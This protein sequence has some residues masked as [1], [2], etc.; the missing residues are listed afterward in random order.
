MH[1]R[2]LGC[3]IAV[4]EQNPTLRSK[5]CIAP[6]VWHYMAASALCMLW[7]ARYWL[8]QL[9]SLRVRDICSVPDI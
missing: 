3:W 6:A 7:L 2:L 5:G 1:V 9:R 4:T 8:P